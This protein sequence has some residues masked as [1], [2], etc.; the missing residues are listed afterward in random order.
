[1][2]QTRVGHD[3]LSG[4]VV[5]LGPVTVLDRA[6]VDGG[7]RSGGAITISSTADVGTPISPFSSVLLPPLPTLPVFPPPSLGDR[8]VNS[9]AILNL[10]P[11]SYRNVTVNSGGTLRLAAG[12]YYFDTLT[13]HSSSTVRATSTTRVFV[14]LGMALRS[15]FR[16]LSGSA[17]QPL[18]L[19][20]AGANLNVETAFDGTLLAPNA[21]VFFGI[22][23]G[24][25]YT[26]AFYA[27]VLDV[28]PQSALV[29]SASAAILPG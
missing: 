6:V 17:V 28:R 21:T 2:G 18:F 1:M 24:V 20:F 8:T 23:S 16:A 9:G 13:I 25:T 3:A 5:S 14:E 19:G 10:A 27:R 26:G 22:G 11:G 15:P 29:C 7:I 12:T 4:G